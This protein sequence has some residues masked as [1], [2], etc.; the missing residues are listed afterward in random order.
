M[1]DK[2]IAI[3]SV[4]ILLILGLGMYF[5]YNLH[6][7]PTIDV[8]NYVEVHDTQYIASSPIEIQS[9]PTNTI[10]KVPK[11]ITKY[12]DTNGVKHDTTFLDYP[13]VISNDTLKSEYGEIAILDS[14]NCSGI[15]GRSSKWNI[16]KEVIV[17]TK[18]ITKNI[19]NP[20][21][22]VSLYGGVGSLMNDKFN[23]L[24]IAPT[25]SLSLKQKHQLNYGYLLNT[26]QHLISLQTRIK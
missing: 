9:K 7:C 22:I 5:G 14:S 17:T 16:K 20:P 19:T 24:D 4:V 26:R 21:A 15:I 18:T 3:V 23:V 11:Y 8:T 12:I 1:K 2:K 6:K 13:M 10:V 25:L